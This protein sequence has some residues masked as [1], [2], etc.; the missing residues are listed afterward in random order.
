[1]SADDRNNAH[2]FIA[3]IWLRVVLVFAMTLPMLVLYATSTLGPLLGRDL[4]F[5][6]VLL[7]YLV[8]SS[9]GVAAVLSLWAGAFVDRIGSRYA[10]IALFSTVASAFTLIAAIENY[11]WS[12]RRHRP[13]WR[14]S[15]PRKSGYEFTDRPADSPGG[16]SKGC[17]TQAIR[18]SARR[19]LRWAWY[20]PVSRSNM[21]GVPRSPWSYPW[22]LLFVLTTPLVTSKIH[23]E[24]ERNRK[25]N[26]KV[27]AFPTK[28]TFA[29]ADGYSILRRRIALRLRHLPANL[30][31]TAWNAP[32]AGR[33]ADC[34]LRCNG[35]AL[36]DRADAHGSKT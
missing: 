10:L 1:M 20:C 28:F 17:R 5:E 3:T 27:R 15:G 26:K 36:A 29:A 34:R 12:S 19:A 31:R 35:H 33:H 23:R 9:F 18:R 30:R 7:G 14:C 22:Q 4:N 2:D 24:T 21:A 8:M 11:S 13:L 6:P 25:G 16:K 32:V